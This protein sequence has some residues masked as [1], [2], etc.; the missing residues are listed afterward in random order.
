VEDRRSLRLQEGEAAMWRLRHRPRVVAAGGSA[1]SGG[2]G[3]GEEEEW[4]SSKEGRRNEEE[5]GQCR[6]GVVG[7]PN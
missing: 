1:G 4:S 3:A 5:Q 6:R 2:G 7:W